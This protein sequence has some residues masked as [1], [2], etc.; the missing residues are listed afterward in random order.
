MA[1]AEVGVEFDESQLRI[2]N[3]PATERRVVV[4]GPGAGKTATSVALISAIDATAGIDDQILFLS[5]SRAAMTAAFDAFGDS[6]RSYN[7]TISAMTLDSLAWQLTGATSGAGALTSADFD[8]IVRAAAAELAVAYDDQFDAVIHLVV[9]EAQDLS[10]ARRLLLGAVIDRL[11]EESGITVFGDPLQSIYDFFDTPDQFA[12]Q[13]WD[14][15]LEDLK[16]RS[17]TTVLTLDGSYRARRRGPRKVATMAHALRRATETEQINLLDDLVSDLTRL[18]LSEFAELTDSWQGT[19]ALLTRTNA[20]VALLFDF[21]SRA[22]IQC[23]W[24]QSGHDQ[25]TVAPW[26]AQLWSAV[27]GAPISAANFYAFAETALD[28]DPSWFR[29]LLHS[30]KSTKMIEWRAVARVCAKAEDPS[31]P[32]FKDRKTG[33][34][35]STIHQAKGLEFDNVAVAGW[36]TM[37]RPN[38]G[39]RPERELLFVAFSRARDRIVA[40]D[41]DGAFTKSVFGTG[42]LVKPHPANE[43]PVEICLTP[44]HFQSDYQVGTELGQH[45]LAG[46]N[47]GAVVEFELLSG[48]GAEWPSYRCRLEGEPVGATT[49]AF[50]VSL[51]KAVRW[52]GRSTGWPSLGSVAMEGTEAA[53]SIGQETKFW[54]KPRPFGFS[55]VNRER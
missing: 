47:S 9:D 29:L 16:T 42:L 1:A 53:W 5:F 51:A 13:S 30:T 2:L 12:E 11:P 3:A 44:D 25:P 28:V 4:A 27:R 10:P 43:F 26:V 18:E 40:L 22:G 19:T 15:L 20:E 33:V 31:D 7:A 24:R 41:W 50:G 38:D 21:L 14:A 32:W 35:I 39:R 34:Q 23:T 52:Q 37:L 46:S 6:D 45:T 36:R 48:R 8:R 49:Q 55:V 54:L 17:I